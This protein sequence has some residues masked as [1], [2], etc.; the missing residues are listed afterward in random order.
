MYGH[1]ITVPNWFKASP[2]TGYTASDTDV[3]TF[4]TATSI[5]NNRIQ[6]G[7]DWWVTRMK[8]LSVWT[9][10]VGVYPYVGGT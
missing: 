10:F 2:W 4:L 7:L 9:K 1:E 3:T 8:A 5:T 6:Y